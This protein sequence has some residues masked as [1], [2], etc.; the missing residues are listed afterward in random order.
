MNPILPL[1]VIL[2]PEVENGESTQLC[3][4]QAGMQGWQPPNVPSQ[5]WTCCARAASHLLN[6][7]LALEVP[8]KAMVRALHERLHTCA[9]E[10]CAL[11]QPGV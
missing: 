11:C 2:T 5:P 6:T 4:T 8:M 7:V 10:C 3:N 1:Y 9:V